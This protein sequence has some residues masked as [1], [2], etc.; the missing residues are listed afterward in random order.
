MSNR[1]MII[2]TTPDGAK[3]LEDA[4][5]K[6][7]NDL[8]MNHYQNVP[9][10]KENDNLDPKVTEF[11]N[12]SMSYYIRENIPIKSIVEIKDIVRRYLNRNMFDVKLIK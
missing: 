7:F 4:F 2:Y 10:L 5:A 3:K 12:R 1:E 9:V 11:F 6:E 8:M